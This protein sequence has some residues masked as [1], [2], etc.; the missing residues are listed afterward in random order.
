MG[1]SLLAFCTMVI[2]LLASTSLMTFLVMTPGIRAKAVVPTYHDTSYTQ[3]QCGVRREV[4]TCLESSD[5]IV[6]GQ[7]A[8]CNEW[9]WQV[10]I[11]KKIGVGS[12]TIHQHHCGGSLINSRHVVTAAHCILEDMALVI[13]DQNQNVKENMERWLEVENVTVH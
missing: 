3:V 9:P 7:D 8:E 4:S 5:R 10:R 11:V 2:S 12:W 6:D 1:R 13:G